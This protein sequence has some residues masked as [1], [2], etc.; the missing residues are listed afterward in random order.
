MSSRGHRAINLRQGGSLMTAHQDFQFEPTDDLADLGASASRFNHNVAAIKLLKSLEAEGRDFGNLTP[1]ER[2][3]LTRYSGWGDTEALNR[4]FPNHGYPRAAIHPDLAGIL[5]DEERKKI[6]ASALNAHYTPIPI[7]RAIYDA[8]LHLGVGSLHTIRVLEPAVGVGHFLGAMPAE[9][10]AKSER[11]AVELDSITARILS[12]LYPNTRVFSKGFEEIALPSDYFDLVVGNVPFGNIPI[13]DPQTKDRHLKAA[14]HDYF[15]ARSLNLAKPGGVIALITSRYTLDK[16]NSAV[17]RHIAK[18][19]ELLAVA[20]L[21]ENAFRKNAGTEVVADV[22]IL[23]KKIKPGS[24]DGNLNWI[25]TLNFPNY[26]GH[27]VPVNKLY[28]ERPQLMLGVPECSRGMY[29]EYEFTLKPDGRSLPEALRDSLISQLPA[30]S[31]APTS[32][33]QPSLPAGD[34]EEKAKA[35]AT[36][37]DRLSGTARQRAVL[38]LDIYTAAKHVIKLQI[39]DADDG[40][41]SE[42]QTELNNLYMRFVSLFGYINA[43]DNLKGL[44]SRSPVVPFLRALEEATRAGG[45]KRAAIFNKRTIRPIKKTSHISSAK[46]ALYYTLNECGKVDID[47]IAALMGQRK[48]VAAA[49]LLG[50]IYE[51]P[52]GHWVTADEYLS[53]NVIKKLKEAQSAAAINQRFQEN[54]DALKAVQ[55]APLGPEEIAARLGAGWIPLEMVQDFIQA[56]IPQFKGQAHYVESL[57]LWKVEGSNYWARSSIEATQTWGTGRMDAMELIEDGLNLRTPKIYDE[58]KVGGVTKR[59]LNETETIA[60]QAKLAEIKLKFVS[61]LWGDESRASKLCDIYNDRYNCLRERRYDGSHLQLPGMNSSINLRPHQSDGIARMIQSRAALFGHCVGAGKTFLTIAGAMELKRLGICH[62]A[63]AVVPNHLPAQWEAEALNLYPD[64]NVLAPRKEDLSAPQRRE[65]MSRIATG[66]YDLIIVPQSAFKLLPTAPETTAHYIQREL[67]RL[68]DYLE[69][70]SDEEQQS[71]QKTLK[72]I[73]R[74][75][76]KLEVR[77]KN[78]ESAIKRDSRHTITWEELGVDLLIFDEAQALKNLYSPTK[79]QNVAGI[80]KSESQRAFDAFIKVRH[81]LDGDGRVVFATATPVSNTLCEIF[82][83]MKFLQLDLLEELGIGHVDAWIQ[84]YAETSQTLEMRP[85]GAGFQMRT[86]L[87]KFTNLPELSR[88]WRQVLDVKNADQLS[89]PSPRVAGGAPRVITV[90]ASDDLK[91]F[92]NSL[93]R[94]AEAIKKR[95]VEPKKDNMLKLTTEGRKAALD[96][97][98]V[99]PDAARPANS[100]VGALADEIV[101]FYKQSQGMLGAQAVFSD[102]GVPRRK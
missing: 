11:V 3:T 41:I 59:V 2:R 87:N 5:T 68:K 21:P 27:K 18:H 81:L 32:A 8:L 22:I 9:L 66:N 55:P 51:T 76:K 24:V 10:A 82:V 16:V 91:N 38:L 23:R 79:T 42:A 20:R 69:G 53:G 13:H 39:N 94:R 85:D 15:V 102:L 78:C 33:S 7:I 64:I 57:G 30:R 36:N 96:I 56:I 44:D 86:R 54:V 80:A 83:M 97:R 35:S 63:I 31:I 19:A 98:L 89:L 52:S 46:D 67:D 70:I 73:Q 95:L 92:V 6:E 101:N 48:D 93:A 88:L 75:I 26:R 65:L 25:D 99:N 4:L 58:V 43:K 29:T 77:L 49:A 45:W 34:T 40:M 61:W 37:L 60:A 71:Q 14:V 50:L 12:Y 72:E 28:I 100:K 1:D 74:A 17:R 47:R 62:K 84:L 90:P